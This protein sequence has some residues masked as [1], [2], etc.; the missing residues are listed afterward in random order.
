MARDVYEAQHK[1]R[2]AADV[3]YLRRKEAIE[4][5]EVFVKTVREQLKKDEAF[6]QQESEAAQTSVN[7]EARDGH[8][9]GKGPQAVGRD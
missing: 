9:D 5:D 6:A 3:E 8:P 1:E 2:A 7:C 4:A